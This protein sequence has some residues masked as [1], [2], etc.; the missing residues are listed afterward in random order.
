M[1]VKIAQ[2]V[3]NGKLRRFIKLSLWSFFVYWIIRAP[4]QMFFT[5]VLGIWYVLSNFIAGCILMVGGF[6]V[7]EFWIWGDK[8]G[9]E[10]GS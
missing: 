9:E 2:L 1:E 7:S 6:L 3:P 10:N 8:G 5:D 4:L